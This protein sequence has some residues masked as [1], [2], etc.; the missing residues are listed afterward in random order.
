MVV[1][2][3][4][5][6]RSTLVS[7]HAF[8]WLIVKLCVRL[9]YIISFKSDFT[10]NDGEFEFRHHGKKRQHSAA[11][12]FKASVVPRSLQQVPRQRRWRK[13]SLFT[14]IRLVLMDHFKKKNVHST[15]SLQCDVMSYEK[16]IVGKLHTF[17]FLFRRAATLLKW[18]LKQSLMPIKIL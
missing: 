1:D 18:S 6:H 12:V 11:V 14:F 8:L 5:M 10:E 2:S 9:V 7:T 17:I 13:W 15:S 16:A 3:I 4:A